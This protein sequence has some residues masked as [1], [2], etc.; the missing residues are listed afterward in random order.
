MCVPGRADEA[1]TGGYFLATRDGVGGRDNPE[2]VR[3]AGPGGVPAAR[4]N[5]SVRLSG[6]E[7]TE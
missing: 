4:A 1:L 5:V 7:S 2:P 3:P 6:P